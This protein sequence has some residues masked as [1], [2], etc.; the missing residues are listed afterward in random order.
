M[1]FIGQNLKHV[2]LTYSFDLLL[3][4]S[5]YLVIGVYF[6]PHQRNLHGK[7]L[8]KYQSWTC[9]WYWCSKNLF[10]NVKLKLLMNKFS[11]VPWTHFQKQ[12]FADVLQNMFSN[13]GVTLA[14]LLHIFFDS[15]SANTHNINVT[16]LKINVIIQKPT[17]FNSLMRE[18][19]I[20]FLYDNGLRH[21]RVNYSAHTTHNTFF[22][23]RV[24][25][26]CTETGVDQTTR[27]R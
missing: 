14:N 7:P 19:I 18:A 21:E 9:F 5:R 4:N 25:K 27:R 12:L 3:I 26:T 1:F 10:F 6:S 2:H 11:S 15:Y 20:I 16:T 24:K 17:I 8:M 22:W 13:A 23:L